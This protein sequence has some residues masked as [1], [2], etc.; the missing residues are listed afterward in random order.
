MVRRNLRFAAGVSILSDAP[1]PPTAPAPMVNVGLIG[2]G[3][4]GYTHFTAA[5]RL[6]GGKVVAVCTRDAKKR[7]GDWTAI[8]GNFGPPAGHVD[9]SKLAVYEDWKDLLADDDVHLVDVCLPTGL[10]EEV[11]VAAAKAGKHVFVEKPLAPDVKAATRMVKAAEKA[12]VSLMC[13]HVLPFMPPFR[14]LHE[15]VTTKKYGLLRALSLERVIAPPPWLDSDDGFRDAGGWG[16]DLHV[17]DTHFV[18]VLCGVPAAVSSVGILRDGLIDHVQTNYHFERANKAGGPVVGSVSGGIAAKGLEFVHGFQ[19]HFEKA[20]VMY[21]GGTLAGEPFED[22]PLTVVSQ[23]GKVRGPKPKGGEEWTSP[24][25]AELQAAVKT[26]RDRE[27]NPILSGD[28]ALAALK[29]VAAETKS[30][31]GGKVVKV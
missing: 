19:A 12:G 14:Y 4:M 22:R 31:A 23:D 5:D 20:T 15:A 6:R 26:V 10:H 27:P 3:F 16:L 29:L 9:L 21:R 25:T 17:H 7:A 13:G 24:F 30:V 2:L 18:S 28:A 1:V 8:R 11:A